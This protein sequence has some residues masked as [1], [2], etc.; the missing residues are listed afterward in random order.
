MF[1][2]C[3]AFELDGALDHVVHEV[4]GFFVV[5]FAVVE[6]NRWIKCQR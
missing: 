3:C 6:N 1:T 2:R 5:G 4:L